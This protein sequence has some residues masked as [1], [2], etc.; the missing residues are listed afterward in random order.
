MNGMN[1][2]RFMNGLLKAGITLDRK[3]LA[4]IAVNDA[5]AF[6]ALADKAKGA[7]AA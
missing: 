1:Y 6:T 7:L 2:S 4:D 3:I 5:T